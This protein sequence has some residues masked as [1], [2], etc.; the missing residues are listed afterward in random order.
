[1]NWIEE[2]RHDI[3]TIK[4]TESDLRKFGVMV[5]GIIVLLS[6]FAL[7]QS[8]WVVNVVLLVAAA[9]LLLVSTGALFP[10]RLKGI[11]KYWMAIAVLLGSIISRVIL[12]ILFFVIVTPLSILAK[13][14]GKKFFVSYKETGRSTYWIA[15]DK[16]KPIN[17]ERM[18]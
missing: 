8:W 2:L 5:G 7:W 17:Y 6:A 3:N 13:I 4:Q 11:H 1:M 12:F 15:R 18:Y 9:G 14:F 10:D 16:N